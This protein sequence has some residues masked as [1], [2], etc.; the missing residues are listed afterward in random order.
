MQQFIADLNITCS[1]AAG[2]DANL[3]EGDILIPVSF[4]LVIEKNKFAASFILSV[5][6]V[7]YAIT[8]PAVGTV[9][10]LALE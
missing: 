9:G 5:I 1:C 2:S 4:I 8:C 3:I 7:R 6:V 10:L